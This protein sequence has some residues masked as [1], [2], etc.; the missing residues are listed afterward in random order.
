M[1]RPTRPPQGFT[2]FIAKSG[3]S[4]HLDR[5]K[6]TVSSS[7][8]ILGDGAFNKKVEFEYRDYVLSVIDAQ[9]DQES[10]F[11]GQVSRELRI[12]TCKIVRRL[13]KS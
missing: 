4:S 9:L 8:S 1:F 13:P 3:A 12:V 11:L 10:D 6:A 5:T 7:L 2:S